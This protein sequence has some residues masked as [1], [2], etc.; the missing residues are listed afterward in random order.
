MDVRLEFGR[1]GIFRQT[2]PRHFAHRVAGGRVGQSPHDRVA[3]PLKREH[4]I[5]SQ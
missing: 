4:L 5:G 2:A 1:T 3:I